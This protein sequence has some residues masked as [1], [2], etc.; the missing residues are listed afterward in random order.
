ML[1]SID[2]KVILKF[3]LG[4]KL[5]RWLSILLFMNISKSFFIDKIDKKK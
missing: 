4:T 3:N 1:L 5:G 2:K